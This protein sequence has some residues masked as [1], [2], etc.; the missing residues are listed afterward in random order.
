MSRTGK[1]IKLQKR[2]L[3]DA[4]RQAIMGDGGDRFKVTEN[5]R[6]IINGAKLACNQLGY[7]S[8][9]EQPCGFSGNKHIEL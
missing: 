9:G 2:I 7:V 6:R 8:H 3:I 1:Y 4:M 5:C